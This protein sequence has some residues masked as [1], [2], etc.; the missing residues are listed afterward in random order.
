MWS[1]SWMWPV[2]SFHYSLGFESGGLS[3][4]ETALCHCH[5]ICS[6]HT[7]MSIDSNL[8]PITWC[9]G[10]RRKQILWQTQIT[11]RAWQWTVRGC[12]SGW[13]LHHNKKVSWFPGVSSFSL[14]LFICICF[15]SRY[16]SFLPTVQNCIWGIGELANLPPLP[17]QVWMS[18]VILRWAE[19]TMAAC[20]L[21]WRWVGSSSRVTSGSLPV[22]WDRLQWSC[23]GINGW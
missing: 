10:H 19:I 18:V 12:C 1:S 9:S 4:G 7:L 2:G 8:S 23:T 20:L 5:T 13:L 15:V 16:S 21:C 11:A 6:I 14:S 22:S 3:G 17:P